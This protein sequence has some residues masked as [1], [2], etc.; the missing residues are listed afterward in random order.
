MGAPHEQGVFYQDQV[1]AQDPGSNRPSRPDGKESPK[2]MGRAM[3]APLH[4]L[5]AIARA[6]GGYVSGANVRC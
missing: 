4:S 5:R 1:P 6:L 2:D 3:N